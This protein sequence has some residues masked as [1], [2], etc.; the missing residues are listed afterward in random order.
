M[1]NF[2]SKTCIESHVVKNLEE[3]IRLQD[4]AANIFE[5]IPTKSALKKSIKKGLV[6]I[7]GKLAYTSDW[8]E[9]GQVISLYA[10]DI[11]Y[12]KK[13]FEHKMDVVYE[14][15]HLA[16]INKP[17]GFPTNGNYFKTV[18]NALPYN[19]KPSK[20]KDCL[21]YPQ[22]VHRL[23][24]P[25][26]GVLLI[27]KTLS[28]KSLLSIL[29]E[30]SNVQKQYLAITEGQLQP[31][32]GK[33]DLDIEGKPSSSRYEVH[34]VFQRGSKEFS[35]V[36]LWPDTGRTH[37]LRIHL[38]SAGH[39]IAGDHQYGSS[40][41]QQLFLHA[42]SVQFKHPKTHKSL[43]IETEIPHKFVKFINA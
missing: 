1:Q 28:C 11:Q 30:T 19:L 16:V 7:N 17:S 34:K 27:A 6:A 15:E 10:E 21:P 12:N 23:D 18:E 26:T 25:T 8:I 4:Y 32:Q 39:P 41:K 38:S 40:I 14:D 24:N 5:A 2:N 43:K 20:E 35:L 22:P 9:N 29:F 36:A 37:Q 33:F 3:K 13:I 42:I 31:E